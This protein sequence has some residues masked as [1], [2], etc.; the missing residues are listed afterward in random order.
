M[1]LFISYSHPFYLLVVPATH[2][3]HNTQTSIP[4][5]D[6]NPQ[7]QKARCRRPSH[8]HRGRYY[9]KIRGKKKIVELL[10]F[11]PIPVAAWSRRSSAEAG[12]LD[13]WIRIPLRTKSVWRLCL[14]YVVQVAASATS[15]SLVQRSPTGC[16]QLCA[17]YEG[18]NFN[19]GNYL[20]TTDTK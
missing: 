9:T 16:V 6:S 19:S 7:S 3:T 1:Y 18:W 12:W 10:N 8:G 20:F 4:P 2:N 5:R 15:W 17:I 13:T 11:G 14:M